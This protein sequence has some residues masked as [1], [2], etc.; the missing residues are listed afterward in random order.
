MN[1][2]RTLYV[3]ISFDME[4][5][6]GSWTDQHLGV[7][8]GT[9]LILEVLARHGVASTFLFT[10]D[11][12]LACPE[13]LQL[14]KSAG[15][16]I[17]CHTLHHESMGPPIVDVPDVRAVLPEEVPNRLARAT[18]LIEE[19]AG[20]RPVSF[21][22]PR[23][24]ASTEMLI[25]LD[26]L[27]YLVDSS[28]MAYYLGE[29]LLPYHPS[30][31]DWKQPGDLRILEVPLFGDLTVEGTDRYKRD[32]DQWPML[33]MRDADWLADAVLR[34]GERLW[35][36]GQ[37]MLAC[38]YL[39]PWEFVEMPSAIETGEARIEFRDYLWW[40]T[41]PVALNQLDRFI[42]RMRAAGAQFHTLHQLYDVWQHHASAH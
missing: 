36:Q 33:R 22:A 29:H 27:G 19:T 18:R 5:D 34:N 26:R 14:I 17:G 11:A 16:E 3:V 35:A 32:R 15:H 30:S 6:I 1:A 25:A 23:G 31:R 37:P 20:V 21:R 42:A 24:W 40:N 4:S 12:A 10:G 7:A 38:L 9:P 2:D 39:H 8:Q 13:A 28:Y 41:G